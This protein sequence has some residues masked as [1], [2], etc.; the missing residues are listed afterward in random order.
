MTIE[1]QRQ[2]VIDG[3][4]Q[5]NLDEAGKICGDGFEETGDAE[6]LYLLAVVK[7]EQQLPVEAAALFERE[8]P[9]H[10]R[11]PTIQAA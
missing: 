11:W 6:F 5:G 1:E 8:R 4:A 10:D 2:R 3:I 9:W 7:T